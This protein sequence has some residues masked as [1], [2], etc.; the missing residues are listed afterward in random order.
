MQWPRMISNLKS[1]LS[2]LRARVIAASQP[3]ILS[4]FSF[5]VFPIVPFCY[6]EFFFLMN[7][8]VCM[9]YVCMGVHVCRHTFV[10]V[11][12]HA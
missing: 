4:H 10:H 8:S 12:V 2:P 1:C 11:H 6:V 7:I 9:M 3:D 5:N